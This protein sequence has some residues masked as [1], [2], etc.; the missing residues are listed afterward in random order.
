MGIWLYEKWQ[1]VTLEVKKPKWMTRY[2]K[3]KYKLL[4]SESKYIIITNK[5][6]IGENFFSPKMGKII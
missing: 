2:F 3:T 6:E 4:K 1:L 5:E